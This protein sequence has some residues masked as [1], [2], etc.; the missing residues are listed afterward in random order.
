M[1]TCFELGT[2]KQLDPVKR[3]VISEL[4]F[5]PSVVLPIVA[6][7]SA[8]LLS[9][10]GGGINYLS[11]AAVLGILGGLGWMSTRIIFNVEQITAE[12]MKLHESQRQRASEAELDQLHKELEQDG[13]P[14]TQDYLTLLRS[15]RDDF[16]EVS[17]RPGVQGRSGQLRERV[18]EVFQATVDRLRDT[19]RLTALARKLTGPGRRK[20]DSEREQL[21]VE[22]VSTVDHL[23]T[24]VREFESLIKDDKRADLTTLR[25]E[26]EA[27]MIVAKLTEKRLR[28]LDSTGYSSNDSTVQNPDSSPR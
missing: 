19:L 1:L 18:N 9:W 14:R 22:I 21:I 23:R 25:E 28:E 12:A 5:A 27:S 15:L 26:L 4:F 20:I 24:T 3:K 10:A 8:A 16:N 17:L 2:S 11:A 13:D 6:G 7:V